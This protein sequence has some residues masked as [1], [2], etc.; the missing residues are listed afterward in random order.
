MSRG[1]RESEFWTRDSGQSKGRQ[2]QGE[3]QMDQRKNPGC[4][5]EKHSLKV[6]NLSE[7]GVPVNMRVK[8]TPG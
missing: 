6:C 7:R 5:P 8:G 1:A 4:H 3:E 2:G